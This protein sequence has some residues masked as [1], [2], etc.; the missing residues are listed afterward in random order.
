[1]SLVKITQLPNLPSISTNTS[2]TLFVGVD[3]L[4]GTTGKFTATVLAQQLYANN[5]LVVGQNYQTIFSNT[6][7]QFSGSDPSFLQVNNQNFNSTGSGD[8]VITADTGTNMVGYID[9]GINLSLIH[10]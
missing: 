8:Y 5:N 10:I 7:G 2:N 4:S 9:L 6:V 1:M 3:L